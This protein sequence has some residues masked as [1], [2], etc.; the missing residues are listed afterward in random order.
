[1]DDAQGYFVHRLT[2]INVF[3]VRNPRGENKYGYNNN[4]NNFRSNYN[5]YN[6]N[7]S[8]NYNNNNNN[9]NNNKGNGD[10]ITGPDGAVYIRQGKGG[11]APPKKRRRQDNGN[12]K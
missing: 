4:Y 3:I 10:T 8:N 5:N 6:N 9:N 12:G 2:R 1:M 7:N 11:G